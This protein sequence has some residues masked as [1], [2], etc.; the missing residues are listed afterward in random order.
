[1]LGTPAEVRNALRYVLGNHAAHALAWGERIR[2][3]WVDP[4]SSAAGRAGRSAQLALW[5]D[6][7]AAVARTWLLRRAGEVPAGAPAP[8]GASGARAPRRAERA[9]R[10]EV[11]APPRLSGT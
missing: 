1:V 9:A 2:E 8:P 6:P 3:T 4:F 5:N 10:P 7:P 11:Q